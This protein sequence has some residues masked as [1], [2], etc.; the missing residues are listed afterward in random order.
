MKARTGMLGL[1]LS[2]VPWAGY[3]LSLVASPG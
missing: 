2:L 1:K 3:L